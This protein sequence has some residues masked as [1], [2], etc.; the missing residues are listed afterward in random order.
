MTAFDTA[1]NL[2]KEYTPNWRDVASNLPE[3]S[4][5]ERQKLLSEDSIMDDMMGQGG[6][7]STFIH[8]SDRRF[9]VKLPHM[10]H[11]K[12]NLASR[13]GDYDGDGYYMT[14]LLESL[15]FPVVSEFNVDDEYIIQPILETHAYGGF[16]E[17]GRP[18]LGIADIPMNHIFGDRVSANWGRDQTGNWRLFDTDMG[19]PPPYDW[20]PSSSANPGQAYQENL[21][22]FNIQL[23]ASSV[24]DILDEIPND[25]DGLR[26]VMESI[27][28]Y[29]DNPQYVT[30]DKKPVW[31]TGY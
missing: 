4:M 29:S 22:K 20:W 25:M 17:L 5:S 28:P 18:T 21:D 15:G 7:L 13:F 14:E 3:L 8:P 26:A 16:G 31:R 19:M 1:W 6:S 24:L 12:D 27:E 2:V 11:S 10:Q 23:P 30:V 9:V